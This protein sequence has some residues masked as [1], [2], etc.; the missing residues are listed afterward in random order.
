MSE[1]LTC[2][3]APDADRRTVLRV[4]GQVDIATAEQFRAAAL[5]GVRRRERLVID[6]EGATLI[7]ASGLRVLS[8]VLREAHRLAR[9]VPVLRGVRPLLARSLRIT[10]LHD[11]F[12]RE[13]ARATDA[14]GAAAGRAARAPAAHGR[15][16]RVPADEADPGP[17][18]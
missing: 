3:M 4:C 17:S 9:P 13:P 18:G 16:W 11:A 6:V 1:Q 15:R 12:A 8:A 2:V 7:D 5:D 10:G 14:S